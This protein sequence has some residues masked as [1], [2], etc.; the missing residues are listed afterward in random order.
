MDLPALKLS[1]DVACRS[2][3]SIPGNPNAFF[4][5]DRTVE[6]VWIQVPTGDRAFADGLSETLRIE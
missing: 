4:M 3:S 5:H 1:I 6:R 2:I